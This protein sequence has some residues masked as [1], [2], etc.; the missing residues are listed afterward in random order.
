V[1]DHKKP[2]IGKTIRRQAK[3]E[4]LDPAKPGHFPPLVDPP[5]P[6][7]A[8]EPKPEPKPKRKIVDPAPKPAKK[9]PPADRTVK[10]RRK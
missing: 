9:K 8:P 4:H 2:R 3:R 5:K 6:E 10:K 7:P 1:I